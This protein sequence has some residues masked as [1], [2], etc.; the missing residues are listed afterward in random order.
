MMSCNV[1]GDYVVPSLHEATNNKELVS[2]QSKLLAERCFDQF[3]FF[4]DKATVP[5]ASVGS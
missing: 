3:D 5:N 4:W 1:Y 2:I